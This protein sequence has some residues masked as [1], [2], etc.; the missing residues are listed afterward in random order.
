MSFTYELKFNIVKS[1]N[2]HSSWCSFPVSDC[3]VFEKKSIHYKKIYFINNLYDVALNQ[4][5]RSDSNQES[6]INN[7]QSNQI[8]YNDD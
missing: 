2:V 1:S 6:E 4:F 8:A 5:K 7:L 3:V